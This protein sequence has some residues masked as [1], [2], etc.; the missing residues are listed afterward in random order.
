MKLLNIWIRNYFKNKIF[1]KAL[2]LIY[3]ANIAQGY[4]KTLLEKI[5]KNIN[6]NSIDIITCLLDYIKEQ[7]FSEYLIYILKALEDNNFLT[8]LVENK[9]NNFEKID[10][11]IIIKLMDKLLNE[12]NSDELVYE[13]KFSFK[14]QIPGF[15]KIYEKISNYISKNINVEY[16]NNEKNLRFYFGSNSENEKK[17]FNEKEYLILMIK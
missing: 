4:C 13:P 11:E 12:I 14:Y 2:D 16:L 10:S 1:A 8:T 6:K 5:L 17:K 9:K 7:I 3:K 15:Y